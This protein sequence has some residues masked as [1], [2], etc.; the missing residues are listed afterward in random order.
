MM[1][2]PDIFIDQASPSDMYRTAG[3]EAEDIARVC[4]SALG[5][6]SVADRRA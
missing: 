3:L 5:V 4:L 1:T 6:A 2:L